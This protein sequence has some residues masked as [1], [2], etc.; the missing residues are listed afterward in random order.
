MEG[1]IHSKE[2]ISRRFEAYGRFF[3]KDDILVQITD[4]ASYVART[5]MLTKGHKKI[6]VVQ[7]NT[8]YDE[9]FGITV[10]PEKREQQ[11]LGLHAH[12]LLHQ[13]LTPF[14]EIKRRTAN[15]RSYE[16]G[17][18]HKVQ[19]ICQDFWIEAAAPSIF[20]GPILAALVAMIRY[21][22]EAAPNLEETNCA[23]GKHIASE[24]C[25][26]L[27]QI[28]DRGPVKGHF[29]CPEAKK[30][31]DE[32]VP[33][34]EEL[35]NENDKIKA[36]DLTDE[37]YAILKPYFD[38]E[39]EQK[40]RE[41]SQ[42][43]EG[44]GNGSD[45][46]DETPKVRVKRPK[47]EPEPEP[48]EDQEPEPE[49]TEASEPDEPGETEGESG[50][51]GEESESDQPGEPDGDDG[52]TDEE[53][54]EGPGIEDT[55][56]ETGDDSDG[57][58]DTSDDTESSSGSD[59]D[60]G[61]K[62]ESDTGDDGDKSSGNE[63]DEDE[64][65]D[66]SD[67]ENEVDG[68]DEGE[69]PE[70]DDEGES[71]DGEDGAETADD[72]AADD[73]DPDT[74]ETDEGSDQDTSDKSEDT[75]DDTDEADE[76]DEDGED[77]DEPEED[78]CEDEDESEPD[79]DMSGG[80][81]DSS[82]GDDADDNGEADSSDDAG[83]DNADNTADEADDAEDGEEDDDDFGLTDEE[84]EKAAEDTARD[85]DNVEK[86]IEREKAEEA[87]QT[88]D[89]I[90]EDTPEMIHKNIKVGLDDEEKYEQLLQINADSISLLEKKARAIIRGD[91][92]GKQYAASG[93]HISIKRIASCERR[94]DIKINRTAPKNVDDMQIHLL[95]DE[96]GSMWDRAWDARNCA[97][98]LYEAFSRL[99]IRVA[100]TGFTSTYDHREE[101]ALSRY[102]VTEKSPKNSR[103]TLAQISDRRENYDAHN[104]ASECEI[105]LK[106]PASHRLLIVI[107]DGA[108]VTLR[109]DLKDPEDLVHDAVCD[110]RKHGI[111]VMAVAIQPYDK[112][113]YAEMY[114]KDFVWVDKTEDLVPQTIKVLSDIVRRWRR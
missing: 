112:L 6:R 45:R 57:E 43:P 54:E 90:P 67:N 84:I 113:L 28:G 62:A 69:E 59:A 64:S 79:D 68:D 33:I 13:I 8:R 77:A 76:A 85:L 93:G 106:H 82:A 71:E 92:G 49:E 75:D 4:S 25:T 73:G 72:S 41:R 55:E 107:S 60:D 9:L 5:A 26:A 27:I 51:S 2:A 14:E 103:F 63:A 44:Q 34:F 10:P 53:E 87:N 31:F 24:I 23:D 35:G 7:I 98:T 46:P 104:I 11:M 16:R 70:D 3:V 21:S 20:A 1:L 32:I 89:D 19:N 97:I 99:G 81:P 50:E 91:R 15:L 96:S 48:E 61:E 101:P 105:M 94:K 83:S 40:I 78:A 88:E 66:N 109:G 100:V 80:E 22:Y 42:M 12:E 111:D 102:Y 39:D 47:P 110:A 52:D 58:T 95:V 29:S 86:D 114:G 38:A 108:P 65:S 37:I 18:Y 36:V 56:A 17:R 30:V 74:S